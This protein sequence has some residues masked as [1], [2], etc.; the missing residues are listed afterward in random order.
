[1]ARHDQ[2]ASRPKEPVDLRQPARLR[3]LIH[4]REHRDRAHDVDRARRQRRRRRGPD[5]LVLARQMPP[6]PTDRL[7]VHVHSDEPAD[8]ARLGQVARDSARAAAEVEPRGKVAGGIPRLGERFEQAGGHDLADRHELAARARQA[9]PRAQPRRRERARG[10]RA[11]R[12]DR[13]PRRETDAGGPSASPDTAPRR[14]RNGST[15][16]P[17]RRVEDHGDGELETSAASLRPSLRPFA[18][19]PERPRETS[20]WPSSCRPRRRGCGPP[21]GRSPSGR[22]ART[23]AAAAGSSRRCWR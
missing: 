11:R 10:W 8:P 5:R 21:C 23:A 14:R 1:M 22:R 19:G 2:Q 18:T 4:V 12:R 20:G 9:D 13:A 16:E 7:A 17:P 15:P 3:R 6:A